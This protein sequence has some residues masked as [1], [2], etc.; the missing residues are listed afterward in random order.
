MGRGKWI[1]RRRRWKAVDVPFT[2][3]VDAPRQ[4]LRAS[5][6]VLLYLL[7]VE[8]PGALICLIES[9]CGNDFYMDEEVE[10]GQTKEEQPPFGGLLWTNRKK[11]RRLPYGWRE[12]LPH[13]APH[14]APHSASESELE[15]VCLYWPEDVGDPLD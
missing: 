1:E 15:T 8:L 12:C 4:W 14:N 3:A 10:R 7:P 5:D 6:S 9:L 11:S 13:N 2:L